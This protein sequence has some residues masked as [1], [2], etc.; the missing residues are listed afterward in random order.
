MTNAY[1]VLSVGTVLKNRYWILEMDRFQ[2][3]YFHTEYMAFD[4]V[5]KKT[6]RVAEFFCRDT[7]VRNPDDSVTVL[8]HDSFYAGLNWFQKHIY[9]AERMP[10]GFPKL[11]DH[12][13]ANGTQYAVLEWRDSEWSLSE[14]MHEMSFEME[15]ITSMKD[16]VE[17]L[18]GAMEEL[19]RL[20]SAGYSFRWLN[21]DTILMDP[22]TK[23]TYL[24]CFCNI[25]LYPDTNEDPLE[26]IYSE[27]KRGWIRHCQPPECCMRRLR[28]GP[29]SA[30]YTL[31]AMLYFLVTKKSVPPVPERML[32]GWS[33]PEGILWAPM[34]TVLEKGLALEP[35]SRYQSVE[36]LR[37]ALRCAIREYETGVTIPVY[38]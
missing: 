21:E 13:Q 29:W 35:A 20:H 6:V 31:C 1:G 18:S 22:E 37:W 30:V 34:R 16:A 9:Y 17:L 24:S 27:P 14:W 25:G 19:S 28:W 3:F 4:M 11:L 15:K 36:E 2:L 38:R 33:I 12:F 5:S 8:K 32:E 23:R 10:E 26:D 7:A